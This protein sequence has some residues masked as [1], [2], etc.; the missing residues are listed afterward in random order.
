MATLLKDNS[1]TLTDL[2]M[3][4]VT[5]REKWITALA[6]V[7]STY[8]AVHAALALLTLFAP[9]FLLDNFSTNSLPLLHT[10]KQEW[11]QW[12][13]AHYMGI[14]QNGYDRHWRAAFFPLYPLLERIGSFA[15]HSPF[16]VGLVVSNIANLGLLMV[17]YQLVKEDFG[18]HRARNAVLY[19]SIFPSAFFFAAAYTESLFLL[20]T[21]LS[22]YQIRHGRWWLA[23]FFGFFACLT[24]STGIFL[25][26]PFVY[27]YL[28]TRGFSLKQIR[29]D[30]IALAMIPSGLI[31]FSVYC[32]WWLGDFLAWDHAQATW[33]HQLMAPWETLYLTIHTIRHGTPGLLSFQALHN[34]LDLSLILFVLVMVALM[35][36]GPARLHREHMAYAV[37]AVPLVLFVLS[38]PI[39]WTPLLPLQSF[40]RFMLEAFPAFVIAGG[41]GR[42]RWFHEGYV[43]VSGS[44]FFLSCLLF[45]TGHW[46]V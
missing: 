32:Q 5:F 40:P 37:W 1:M 14:A 10:F 23:G 21:L 31:A 6:Q 38:V 24:R 30:I 41:I 34:L 15:V 18:H 22:F 45:L 13:T 3:K 44:L 16:L 8:F 19:L 36:I 9:L 46:M 12:D 43:L 27:E 33:H 2:S 7:A 11:L 26:L 4:P 35:F 42:H 20:L 29:L 25:A 39:V 28:R 17:L